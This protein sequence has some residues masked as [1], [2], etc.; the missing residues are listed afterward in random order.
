[1]FKSAPTLIKKKN[2]T[3]L[4]KALATKKSEKRFSKIRSWW[5]SLDSFGQKVEFTFKGKRTY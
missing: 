2:K 5:L 4:V 3:E 1:M